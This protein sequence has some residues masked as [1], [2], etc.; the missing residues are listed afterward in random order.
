M[1]KRLGWGVVAILL[2]LLLSPAASEAGGHVFF[3]FSIPLGPWWWGPPAPYYYP[4]YGYPYYAS[5][6]VVVQQSP[7]V[8]IQQQPSKQPA[9]WYYCPN[10]QGYYPYV[11]E[12]SAGWLTVVPP[13]N[14]PPAAPAP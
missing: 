9:Y 12:C 6:P 2:V 13:S 7:S 10:P 4:Y 1:K 8:Y 3:N 11:K 5:P 14:A